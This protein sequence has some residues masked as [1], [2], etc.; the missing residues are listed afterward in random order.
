MK[1]IFNTAELLIV[2]KTQLVCE[3]D[4]VQQTLAVFTLNVSADA[5]GSVQAHL[6]FDARVDTDTELGV[7]D[8][9]ERNVLFSSVNAR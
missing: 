1:R 9:I 6:N 2:I 4:T 7:N 8:A 5:F 3:N